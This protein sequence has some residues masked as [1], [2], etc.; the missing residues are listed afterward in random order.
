MLGFKKSFRPFKG[1]LL[2]CVTVLALQGCGGEEQTVGVPTSPGAGAVFQSLHQSDIVQRWSLKAAE[3]YNASAQFPTPLTEVEQ[4]PN[5]NAEMAT[6]HVAMFD[7]LVALRIAVIT[8]EPG[9]F[10]Y[11]PVIARGS[12]Y[13]RPGP[14][15]GSAQEAAVT[16]AA[17]GVLQGLWP[18]RS[19]LYQKLYDDTVAEL[20]GSNASGDVQ[21]GLAVG[22]DIAVQVLQARASD[23]R[24]NAFGPYVSG[25][26][27]G[28]Y[29]LPPTSLAAPYV[30]SIKPFTRLS[31]SYLRAPGPYALTDPRYATDFNETRDLG[32]AN[33]TLRTAEQTTAARFQ[34]EAPNVFWPRNLAQFA[35]WNPGSRT[36]MQDAQLSAMLW[37]ALSD[38]VVT[39][40]DSKFHHYAWRPQSA[41]AMADT[42][43]NNDTVADAS[44]TPLGPVPPHPEY[45]AA[46]TCI[47][48]AVAE[49]LAGVLGTRKLSFTFDAQTVA[50]AVPARTFA[51][52]DEMVEHSFMARIWG[53]QHFRHALEDGRTIGKLVVENGL[54]NRYFHEDIGGVW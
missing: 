17:Y 4:R 41:I 54:A 28:Q 40:W 24:M 8:T 20:S 13:T 45:P 10:S 22:A 3:T 51:N 48:S 18:D 34:T 30:A 29:R 23:G 7:A 43:G 2:A 5:W 12:V 38:A 14:Y 27:P 1:S 33:S 53:G 11:I 15:S 52:V 36:L 44:W 42:D 25:A 16:A 32:G 49:T 35:H 31:A 19:S 21:T 46:H 47:S 26:L 9:G 37:V 39:C 50:P 6:V